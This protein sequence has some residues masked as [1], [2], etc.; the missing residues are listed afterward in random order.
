[1]IEQLCIDI[2][3]AHKVEKLDKF[4]GGNNI[5]ILFTCLPLKATTEDQ[6]VA[7]VLR[8]TLINYFKG[9]PPVDHCMKSE[10]SLTHYFRQKRDLP[11]PLVLAWDCAYQN[12]IQCPY[13]LLEQIKG[14]TLEFE[15]FKLYKS[16]QHKTPRNSRVDRCC[17]YAR[18]VADF[19]A[20]M[21][22]TELP[23]YGLFVAPTN[24]PNKGIKVEVD[25][26]LS[27]DS[28]DGIR[29]PSEPNFP[30][31]VNN[32]LNAQM[33]RTSDIFPK[34]SPVEVW[35]IQKLRQIGSQMAEKG[36]L[37]SEPSVLWHADFYPRNIMVKNTKNHAIL[38]GVIDWDEARAFPRI[39]AR[40]PPSW[41]W[42][43]TESPILPEERDTIAA[44]FYDQMEMLR[45]GY[46]DDACLPSKKAVRALCM[47][48]VFGANFKHYLELSFDSLVGYWEDFMRKEFQ[49]L[50]TVNMSRALAR[51]PHVELL[52]L[53]NA[54]VYESFREALPP[55]H[56]GKMI[57]FPSSLSSDCERLLNA[58]LLQHGHP[59]TAAYCESKEGGNN[60]LVVFNCQ[61]TPFYALLKYCIRTPRYI[62]FSQE[63][64]YPIYQPVKTLVAL[65]RQFGV[66]GVGL[67]IPNILFHDSGFENAIS[68]PYVVMQMISGTTLQK[69]YP[70][71]QRSPNFFPFVLQYCQLAR[72]IAHFI[73]KKESVNIPGYSILRNVTD[74]KIWNRE[75]PN[76]RY[77]LTVDELN[78]A[79]EKIPKFDFSKFICKLVTKEMHR[80]LNL[81]VLGQRYQGIKLACVWAEM[82]AR[83]LL[84]DQDSTLWHPDFHP[85]NILIVRHGS[86][87][88]LSGVIDWDNALALP[89]IMTREP[90]SFLWNQPG[91]LTQP[92]ADAVKQAFDETIEQLVPGYTEDTYSRSRVLI[93]ALGMYSLY[94][95]QWKHYG[96]IS[97]DE[98]LL[99]CERFFGPELQFPI[100]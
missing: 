22:K 42:S 20:A 34:V 57:P 97:F 60:N 99:E 56:I 62:S 11:I 54:P 1:M 26:Q 5:A 64:Q 16:L 32:I 90:P 69:L 67:P 48:A 63:R 61:A 79:G 88:R 72:E 55:E 53:V 24:M 23:G 84:S 18:C 10:V 78:I 51:N 96:E 7:C 85:R 98:F 12:S 29:I 49:R 44:A 19:V 45:P 80:Y 31:W 13:T 47:Y 100:I 3:F 4:V 46:K 77:D 39:V 37:T 35:K 93:R 66:H 25:F 95:P 27:R 65:T 74:T 83:D 71:M 40:N 82:A 30:N 92:E 86:D 89:R 28:I 17:K 9:N 50:E 87:I 70:T 33:Q 36:L 52:P 15:Y 81:E 76:A 94:G 6:R 8:T 58:L 14:K 68:C 91:V 41:L 59:E 21:D 43:M 75:D 2:N 38:T 73:A